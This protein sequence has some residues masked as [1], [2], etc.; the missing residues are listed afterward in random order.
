MQALAP[1]ITQLDSVDVLPDTL[2][3]GLNLRFV[4]RLAFTLPSNAQ[5]VERYQEALK[6]LPG[7]RRVCADQI[8][9]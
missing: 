6:Q 3:H 9:V 7:L 4:T 2:N 1:L 5:H 8:L